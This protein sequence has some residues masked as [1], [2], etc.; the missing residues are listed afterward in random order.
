ME[1]AVPSGPI[2]AESEGQTR[3][4]ESRAS[5]EAG[6]TTADVCSGKRIGVATSEK[7]APRNTRVGSRPAKIQDFR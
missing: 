2:T 1:F 7:R 5:R 6:R 4:A 3:R